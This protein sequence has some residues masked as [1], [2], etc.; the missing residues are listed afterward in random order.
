VGSEDRR[1]IGQRHGF[2]GKIGFLL[3]KHSLEAD[4]PAF[5]KLKVLNP[6]SRK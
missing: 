3:T 6:R 4:K 1:D 5:K 2:E